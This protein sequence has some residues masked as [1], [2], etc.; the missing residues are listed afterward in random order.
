MRLLLFTIVCSFVKRVD[1]EIPNLNLNKWRTHLNSLIYISLFFCLQHTQALSHNK[2]IPIRSGH[3]Y[4][5]ELWFDL[6]IFFV[7]VCCYWIMVW[8]APLFSGLFVIHFLAMGLWVGANMGFVVGDC[9]Y[10][11]MCVSWTH[12][13]RSYM[14]VRRRSHTNLFHQLYRWVMYDDAGCPE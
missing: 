5:Y 2:C 10:M 11:F 1:T 12:Q 7:Y 4:A 8:S 9:K 6:K 3:A 13:S 14:R